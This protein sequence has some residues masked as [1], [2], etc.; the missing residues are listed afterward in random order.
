[1]KP[2]FI[3]GTRR[4]V[5][6]TSLSIGL[7]HACRRRGIKVGY[8]KPLGQRPKTVDGR[9]LHEDALV[10]SEA[11]GLS[12]D[13][14]VEMAVPLPRGRV[15]KEV[16][17]L[18]TDDLLAKVRQAY[19]G[20]RQDH[21]LVI[22]EGMGHV[23][24]GSCLKL[25]AAEVAREID[26]KV[27]LIGGGGIGQAIDNLSLSWDFLRFR[28]AD[29]IGVILNKVWPQKYSYIKETATRGLANLDIRTFGV[30]PFEEQLSN[31]TIRQVHEL[32][33]GELLSGWEHEHDLVENT[34]IAAMAPE[35][36]IDYLKPSTLV[37]VPGDNRANILASLKAHMLGGSDRRLVAGLILTGDLRPDDACVAMFKELRVPVILVPDDTYTAASTFHAATFKID[38]NDK[39]KIEWAICLVAEYIDVDG[40][41]EQLA[42]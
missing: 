16:H 22:V 34:I 28:G 6:K 18:H 41:L 15:G 7:L 8:T 29:P 13:H 12:K 36:M 5:G 30:L 20:A 32:L 35:R 17:D 21:D 31:P 10:V 24:M 4:D 2:L 11:M 23:G 3:G 25:S 26:A 9:T 19:E 37:I 38:P 39:Q 42:D 40:I 33:D 1:M 27:L 14:Q